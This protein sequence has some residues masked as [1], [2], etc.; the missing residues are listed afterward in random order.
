MAESADGVR[1]TLKLQGPRNRYLNDVNV[2]QTICQ[3]L[4]DI[5]VKTNC[6]LMDFRAEFIPLL[7]EEGYAI[8]QDKDTWAFPPIETLFADC[9]LIVPET[10]MRSVL[11]T[12]RISLRILSGTRVLD[13]HGSSDPLP[14]AMAPAPIDSVLG[15]DGVWRGRGQI[16]SPFAVKRWESKVLEAGPVFARVRLRY[17]FTGDRW[18]E[19]TLTAVAGADWIEVSEEGDAGQASC[20]LLHALNRDSRNVVLGRSETS[21]AILTRLPAHAQP[22][23]IGG[24]PAR[25]FESIASAAGKDLIAIFSVQ[26]GTWDNSRGNE[27]NLVRLSGGLAFHF[28][29]EKGSR[30][31]GIMTSTLEAGSSASICRAIARA[32]DAS[33]DAVLKMDLMP[34]GQLELLKGGGS[35]KAEL[36]AAL[37]AAGKAAAGLVAGGYSGAPAQQMDFAAIRS[38]AAALAGEAGGSSGKSLLRARLAF[39]GNA[40]AD[41]SFYNHR[42]LLPASGPPGANL[43]AET[44][45][46]TLN[47]QRVSTLAEIALALPDYARSGQWLQHAEEQLDLMLRQ[48]VGPNGT[49]PDAPDGQRIARELAG[50]LAER[51]AGAGRRD[52]RNEPGFK[53]LQAAAPSRQ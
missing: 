28:P 35:D 20:L 24:L 12:G 18:W 9:P 26:P 22:A 31:W 5:G 11:T 38:A 53:A 23:T 30:R 32:S 45:N 21:A 4:D 42:L 47:L 13:A 36:A 2:V 29:L 39:I 25:R 7:R 34:K 15:A 50:R 27:I 33:L 46:W 17:E 16:L 8:A 52:L 41:A 40:L 14:A 44:C 51:L 3:Y 37:E 19:F 6:Q 48:L 49:W 10:I 1:F 43:D